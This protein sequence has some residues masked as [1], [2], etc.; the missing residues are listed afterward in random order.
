MSIGTL[1][2]SL[3]LRW[4]GEKWFLYRNDGQ[5]CELVKDFSNLKESMATLLKPKLV[6]LSQAIG[7]LPQ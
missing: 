2:A 4:D 6:E 1:T 7:S 5:Y 3:E